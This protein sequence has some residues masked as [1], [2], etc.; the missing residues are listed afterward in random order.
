[1]LGQV[2][3]KEDIRAMLRAIHHGSPVVDFVVDVMM[4]D[5]NSFFPTA[6]LSDG[7]RGHFI[8]VARCA[9]TELRIAET[10]LSNPSVSRGGSDGLLQATTQCLWAR[11]N[12]LRGR[13]QEMVKDF[14][15]LSNS[16]ES[17]NG[18]GARTD[19]LHAT[20]P[21]SLASLERAQAAA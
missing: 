14:H 15:M 6:C 17:E 10:S 16:Q 5:E 20:L 21:E 2:A 1:M 3:S 4:S 9:A 19:T 12:K 18:Q 11:L 7:T 8:E 13:A